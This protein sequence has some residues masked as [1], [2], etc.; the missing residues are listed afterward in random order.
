[1]ASSSSV[2]AAASSATVLIPA[3]ASRS[4]VFGPTPGMIRAGLS[5]IT[6]RKRSRGSTHMPSG[7]SRSEAIFAISRFGPIPT[8]QVSRVRSRTRSFS[9]RARVLG[10]GESLRST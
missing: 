3:L 7:L 8:E 10:A 9:A 1:M 4:S 6:S 2:S 5:P